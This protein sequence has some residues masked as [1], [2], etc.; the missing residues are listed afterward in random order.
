MQFSESVFAS[1]FG[2]TRPDLE[3]YLSE[4]LSQGGDYA[5]LYF[6]YLLTSSISIDESMVKSA[7]QG[8]SMGVGI[9]VISGERTGYAYSD[10]LSPEKIRK[11]ANVAA[12]IAAAPAK[13]EKFDLNEGN[14]HNLYPVLI[15]PSETA[16]RDR[17]DL[18]KRADRAARAFDPRI[19]QV[20]AVY[21]DNLRQVMVATSEGVLTLDRQPLARMSV[22]A[23]ARAKDGSVPQRGHSGGG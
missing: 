12:H 11:A 7:T 18:V 5:D 22:S 20:Q 4:A 10:D 3:S 21:A 19:F 9:R 17:V 2:I 14:K 8:V 1:R 15:A 6:E 13:V 16:F 23:L